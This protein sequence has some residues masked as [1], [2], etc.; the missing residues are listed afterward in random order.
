MKWWLIGVVVILLLPV[1]LF[2]ILGVISWKRPV[3]GLTEGK[4]SPC[5][6]SPNCV[7]SQVDASDEHYIAPLNWLEGGTGENRQHLKKT[8][9]KIPR[10]SLVEE[11]DQYLRYEFVS[12]IFRFADDVEFL[13]DEEAREIHVRSASRVGYSDLGANRTRVEAIRKMLQQ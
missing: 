2:F 6:E 3:L 5:P 7:C 4:L 11:S 12:G 8:L 9:E 13:F 1:I 10:A